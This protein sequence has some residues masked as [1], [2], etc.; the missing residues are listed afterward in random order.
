MRRFI[1][2]LAL[3]WTLAGGAAAAA[4]FEPDPAVLAPGEYLWHPEAAPEGPLVMIVS[5]DEQR[6]YVYRNGIAIGLSTIS[7]G[8]K[9]HETPTG[10]FTI[11]QKDRDHR[12]NKYDNA[13]MPFME[14]LTWDGIALHGGQ[15]PGHPASHGC[16]RLPQGFAEKLYSITRRGETVVVA[17][18][19]VAPADIVHPA[20]LA[21]VTASGTPSGE[22]MRSD[23]TFTWNEAASPEGPVSVLVSVPDR[24][25]HVLRNGIRIGSSTLEV[26]EGLDF[27]GSV[28]F[29]MLQ[30]YLSDPAPKRHRWASYPV[31]GGASP[32]MEELAVKLRVPDEFTQRLYPILVP[33]T[34]IL[35][36]DLPAVRSASGRNDAQPVLESDAGEGA[37]LGDPH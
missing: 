8:R 19:K 1:Q 36:T 5:L 26:A 23:A 35:V 12:S 14:R 29:V 33:G 2:A 37:R 30:G 34:S 9:G 16:V 20:V 31:R 10:V 18:A 28:V 32:S 22:G 27:R 4:L 6:V 11:L 24:R 17:D 3:V 15:L 21:P 13:P 25:V 7:S